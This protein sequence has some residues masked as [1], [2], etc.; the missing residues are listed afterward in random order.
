VNGPPVDLI[1]CPV[2]HAGLGAHDGGLRCEGCGR[3]F[4]GGPRDM[5]PIPPPDD[6]LQRR[7]PLWEQLQANFLAAA[8]AV[9][10]H[11][12]SVTD[13]PDA[14]AFA[15][16]CAMAGLVVDV[17]CGTQRLPT[18]ADTSRCRFV[19]IDPLPGERERD[20][21]FLQG[22]GEYLPF[23]TGS[24]D[25]VIFA[26]SL[27]H[28]LVPSRA[29]VEAARVVRPGGAVNVWFGELPVDGPIQRL[30]TAAGHLLERWGLRRAPPPPEPEP[31]YIAGIEQPEGAVDKFHVAHPTRPTITS[32]LVA[33]GLRPSDPERV[34]YGR[35]CFIRGTKPGEPTPQ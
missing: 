34:D 33:A 12:L 35:G 1:V 21:E 29:L 6:E 30:R 17:G 18:Y 13:R 23:R 31:H 10:E 32:W 24:V 20:F 22:L 5:T 4:P 19:G 26:T 28:M 9:P 27:D 11:S 3:S 25:Q 7:W 8:T 15:E 16:F 2:C 14:N